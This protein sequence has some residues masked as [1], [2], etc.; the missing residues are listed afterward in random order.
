M[1][2]NFSLLYNHKISTFMK[3]ILL[4]LTFLFSI[5]L[6]F[7]QDK[8]DEKNRSCGSDEIHWI[9]VKKNPEYK[10]RFENDNIAW[11]RY[12][13]NHQVQPKVSQR[14]TTPANNV[15]LT[16][17]FHNMLSPLSGTTSI[18]YQAVIDKLNAV[19]HGDP[20]PGSGN[21]GS[22]NDT[23]VQFCLAKTDIFGNEYKAAQMNVPSVIHQLPFPNNASEIQTILSEVT[24]PAGAPVRFPTSNF[25]NI[26]VVDDIQG[27]VAGFSSLPSAHGTLTDGFFME[28][29]YLTSSVPNHM[30]VLIHE[31]GH[32]LGLYHIFGVC[33]PL[34]QPWNPCYCTNTDCT[35]NGDAVCDTDPIALDLSSSC[36]TVATHSCS[37]LIAD[38]RINY[39]DYGDWGC[40]YFFSPGQ[41]QKMQ[42]TIDP[43]YGPRKSLVNRAYCTNC[44][45]L[46]LCNF[47]VLQGTGMINKEVIQG[48]SAT[49]SATVSS[50]ATSGTFTYTWELSLLQGST[51]TLV[52]PATP[53]VNFSIP[54]SLPMGNYQIKLRAT[55]SPNCFEDVIFDFKVVPQQPAGLCLLSPPNNTWTGWLQ[56]SYTGGCAINQTAPYAY[57]YP[58]TVRSLESGNS[59]NFEVLSPSALAASDTNFAAVGATGLPASVTSIFRVGRKMDGTPLPDGSAAFT[60]VKFKP[61]RQNCK[62]RIY[63][64][65]V[66]NKTSND[67]GATAT[68]FGFNCQYNY[69]SP[70]VN[71]APNVTTIIGTTESGLLQGT[72]GTGNTSFIGTPVMAPSPYIM[73]DMYFGNP[74]LSPIQ[75]NTETVNIFG[76]NS[77]RM[78]AWRSIV[79]DFSEFVDANAEGLDTEITLTFYAKSDIAIVA[80]SHSYA[81]FGIECLGGGIPK[82]YALN[83]SD[84]SLGCGNLCTSISLPLPNYAIAPSQSNNIK[85]L[86]N[87]VNMGRANVSLSYDVTNFPVTSDYSFPSN[88]TGISYNLTSICIPPP[89]DN[90]PFI[91]CR[92]TVKTLHQ[93]VSQIIR[94]Y[95]PASGGT[96]PTDAE[97]GL[98]Y[99]CTTNRGGSIIGS[100]TIYLCSDL[101]SQPTLTVGPPCFAMPPGGYEYR[102]MANG[103][104]V[105]S[106][107]FSQY[108]IDP[109]DFDRNCNTLV[110]QV[111]RVGVS[112]CGS[113]EKWISSEVYS[114]YKIDNL[115]FEFQNA[116]EDICINDQYT[117]NLSNFRIKSTNSCN[118]P[119]DSGNSVTLQLMT[120]NNEVL[121][122]PVSI[123]NFNLNDTNGY[124]ASL[125]FQNMISAGLYHFEVTTPIKVVATMNFYGCVR[126]TSFPITLRVKSSA[127]GGT[128][129][130]NNNC[131]TLGISSINDGVTVP[132][133]TYQWQISNGG[134]AFVTIPGETGVTLSNI[135]SALWTP[136][137]AVVR[138]VSFGS[139]E[140]PGIVYSNLITLNPY[141]T[142]PIFNTLPNCIGTILPNTSDNGITGTWSPAVIPL[143]LAPTTYTF[144]PTA[145]QCST[146]Y[147]VTFPAVNKEYPIFNLPASVCASYTIT[148]NVSDNGIPGTWSVTNINPAHYQ[149]VFTPAPGY[150]S[151]NYIQTFNISSGTVPIFN[152]ATQY[153]LGAVPVTLP[154][155]SVNG[156]TGVWNPPTVS[157]SA[158]GTTNYI[159]TANT[160]NNCSGATIPITIGN[161]TPTFAFSSNLNLCAGTTPPVLPLTSLNGVTG[162]WSPATVN[163]STSGNYTFT[164]SSLV[165]NNIYTFHVT[166]SPNV[167]PVFPTVA[168]IC[169]GDEINGGNPLPTT[170]NNGVTGAWSPPLN[171][172]STTTYTFTPNPGQCAGPIQITVVVNPYVTPIFATSSYSVCIGGSVPAFPTTSVNGISGYWV[173][174][175]IDTGVPGDTDYIF[176]TAVSPCLTEVAIHVHVI[177]EPIKPKFDIPKTYCGK[178]D[179]PALP[180]TS[181]DGIPGTWSPSEISNS[182]SGSYTFT[183]AAAYSAC[184]LELVIQVEII[185]NTPIVPQFQQVNPI[186][187]G[188]TFYLPA[189]SQNNV[190]GFWSPALDFTATTLYTFTPTSGPCAVPT[191]M[192]VVVNPVV[193]PT[194]DPIAPIC[195]GT[196]LAP[197]STIST[198]GISGTWSPALN[199]Q[200]TTT[201]TFTPG[202]GLCATTTTLT[203][204]VIQK[205]IPVFSL[206]SPVSVCVGAASPLPV[207]S[208]NNI[209]GNWTPAFSSTSAG[210][211]TYTFTPSGN[212]CATTATVTVSVANPVN[213]T[214]TSVSVICTG[215]TLAQLPSTS[216]N[217]IAGSWS[218]ATMNNTATTVYTFTPNNGLCANPKVITITV[219]QKT[220]PTFTFATSVCTGTTISPLPTTSSNSIIG[221]WSPAVN[222]T[223]TTTYTFTPSSGQCANP[224]T[225][226]ITI[227]PKTTPTFTAVGP[228]CQGS[229]LTALPTTSING[230]SGT[231]T[232][233][234]NNSATTTYTF[235]PTAGQCA[236]P[237]TMSIVITPKITPAFSIVSRVCLGSS[238]TNPLPTTSN[239]GITGTWSP[240]FNN[241]VTTTYTFTPN[242]GQCANPT[243]ATILV[244]PV[245]AVPTV[246]SPITYC[247]NATASPLTAT[248]VAG[249]TFFWQ[250]SLTGPKYDSIIPVTTT[251]GETVYYVYQAGTEAYC[252]SGL[253]PIVV[254]VIPGATISINQPV[255]SNATGSVVFEGLST[256]GWTIN[257][258]NGEGTLLDTSTGTTNSYTITGLI[259]GLHHYSVING[260]G[261]IANFDVSIKAS[262]VS[263]PKPPKAEV[264]HQSSC[265]A[266]SL[267]S[268]YGL[269]VGNWTITQIGPG[270]VETTYPI[271]E[272][273]F[274]EI[275]GLPPGD[276]SYY[277]TNA[278]GCS[279]ELVGPVTIDIG[280]TTTIPSYTI[281]QP[282]CLTGIGSISFTGLTDTDW[283]IKLT[284]PDGSVTN[285]DGHWDSYEIFDLVAGTYTFSVTNNFG[286]VSEPVTVELTGGSSAPAAPDVVTPVTYYIGDT[287]IPLT[288]TGDNLLWYY[289]DDTSLLPDTPT[290]STDIP[291]EYTYYVSQTVNGCESGKIKLTVIVLNP[292][293]NFS[294]WD[295]TSW[296]T[297]SPPDLST[298]VLIDG[299]YDMQT[300]LPSFDACSVI[301]KDTYHVVVTPGNYVNIMNN[302]TVRPNA[303]FTVQDDGSLV[304]INDAGINT[305]NIIYNRT[306]ALK[307]F[308]Y[309]YWSSPVSNFNTSAVSPAT[310]GSFIF[311]W[312]P[313]V[314]NPNGSRGYW[315]N[316][317]GNTMSKGRGYII[318]APSSYSPTPVDFTATFQNGVPNNGII[319]APVQKGS[320][321]GAPIPVANSAP[322]T[323]LTD[324]FNL[325]G[326][327]YPSAIDTELFFD[328]PANQDV[329]YG[330]VLL[331]NH[332]H[333]PSSGNINPFYQSFQI[334]YDPNDY[335]AVNN[336]G[337]QAGPG[338]TKI[339]GGQGFFVIMNDNPAVAEIGNVVTFNNA[340]RSKDFDNSGFYKTS[341][342]NNS[343]E[344]SRI[345]LDL[346]NSGNNAIRTLV[347]YADGATMGLD[348]SF[349]S[350][351]V[352]NTGMSI[353][354][355]VGSEKVIIQG[356]SPF[357]IDDE[358]PL[359]I[360]IATAGTYSIAI[361]AL[362]GI[363]DADQN[364]YLKDI[365][366][367]QY[368]HLKDSPYTFSATAGRFEN[369]FKIVFK[370]PET[371]KN[372]SRLEVH[373]SPN[374]FKDTI[375]LS[376]TSLSTDITY[377]KVY[378]MMGKLLNNYQLNLVDKAELSIGES[379]PS[380]VYN[381]VVNQGENSKSFRI[382]KE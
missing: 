95:R 347:G 162:T 24:F 148:Q 293:D 41:V 306:T 27:S 80:K 39:M 43:I 9:N 169:F 124:S 239:N 11:S 197:L 250:Y 379:I 207:T 294:I 185:N 106:E 152:F 42:Y 40:F 35:V 132:A 38:Q 205:T 68:S 31:M 29:S 126:T 123:A 16:V 234:L 291:G 25:I 223:A 23:G 209:A 327:P 79:V 346:V 97:L 19:Y 120:T 322:I 238:I 160:G 229:T 253:T 20:L 45:A 257:T 303:T 311:K 147:T 130:Q 272:N 284:F 225:V 317:A 249:G 299:D 236:N 318:R 63:Y 99:T 342:T 269:S 214:F 252:Q 146:A 142:A 341:N 128:I 173:P 324:N 188:G 282:N 349:D 70:V 115:V 328:D 86:Y 242:T 103:I 218:P 178:Q 371:L 172:L 47:G 137:P 194:F 84:I 125:S 122:A 361:A 216:N 180:T 358:V 376:F 170:S 91:Y 108:T 28:R 190:L 51:S 69:K 164:P 351:G 181:I 277:A 67:N 111:K 165:C 219:N 167:T 153:C 251:V 119:L 96:N 183:P 298:F 149:S 228:F 109:L 129:A 22:D 127:V 156:I 285:Y 319:G 233:V 377:V 62:Y 378:D 58:T 117:L 186:C 159:F 75:G 116:A 34:G 64:L 308:D 118:F 46:D 260:T 329:I 150:C 321:I 179:I 323:N 187:L 138:R 292:C 87:L 350:F 248:G 88:A 18:N 221:T 274:I 354:S 352:P 243:M 154:T 220:T 320:Y 158:V 32:Y 312:E 230:I 367:D 1:T 226:T 93:T 334:N 85:W 290:P 335:V 255:C 37:P 338:D 365:L 102:W 314:M 279:T 232:P 271:V 175:A 61:T 210:V 184:V 189:N 104:T 344:K 373:Y 78:T 112:Y 304:Q 201:Y 359:G 331:W 157:T 305:G 2:R 134:G 258:L 316:A 343:V 90:N 247:L 73:N 273:S 363:F 336:L 131:V 315:V 6:T 212:E 254:N 215:T 237:A 296:S 10:E 262:G 76:S 44:T 4:F 256:A 36:T 332:A 163:G 381:I 143:W 309:V 337:S 54:S 259:A 356:R 264:I 114:V 198:N 366:L 30:T 224:K 300:G 140:C 369:R 8:N 227:N 21:A 326:N 71:P 196:T 12:A 213:P 101:N 74:T 380:G 56:S 286:C 14:L 33:D 276:Y 246:I 362:D 244:T 191:T 81:Y 241:T 113:A 171:N 203:I 330:T 231:W 83:L 288:A 141:N 372:N 17:V 245:A 240:G 13:K 55:S 297:G 121:S 370:I 280:P 59:A 49:V 48:S 182:S 375:Q 98:T 151:N 281:N 139:P 89:P 107:G 5:N 368:H 105:I 287:A 145:G 202:S 235:T 3:R 192:T 266:P 325:I 339:A 193:T 307:Q 50:C 278:E 166:I 161:I 60:S 217:G 295:G 168:P 110:R 283:S 52:I 100:N 26:Y 382:I 267:V 208:N 144:T 374:P 94:I 355:T 204:E 72:M 155:T 268:V 66:S 195:K 270:G 136:T 345:W 15:V 82:N 263:P 200:A 53:G 265:E 340:M 176:H 302:L 357:D 7:S 348:R 353:Y 275:P 333:I 222:N 177:G 301:V 65:G 206:N 364:V 57:T 174:T 289:P 211:T 313:L 360:N 77:T 135:S 199:N 261:C 133:G 310:S 92:V